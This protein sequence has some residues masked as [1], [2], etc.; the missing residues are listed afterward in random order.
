[1][2]MGE[3]IRAIVGLPGFCAARKGGTMLTL[4][5]NQVVKSLGRNGWHKWTPKFGDLAAHDWFV[6]APEQIKP[7]FEQLAAEAAAAQEQKQGAPASE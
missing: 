1:M 3:A 5:G 2:Q 6:L 7:Y 4:V